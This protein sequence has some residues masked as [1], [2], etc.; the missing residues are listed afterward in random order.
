MICHLK[1]ATTIFF[2]YTLQILFKQVMYVF[3]NQ[4]IEYVCLCV[5]SVWHAVKTT[6]ANVVQ[7]YFPAQI[8]QLKWNEKGFAAPCWRFIRAHIM[9]E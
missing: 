3:I 7:C 2:N 4:K 5:H 9:K 8:A 1:C 6:R